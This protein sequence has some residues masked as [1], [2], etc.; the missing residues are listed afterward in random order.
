MHLKPSNGAGRPVGRAIVD[1]L[2][3][4]DDSGRIP[5]VGVTG[6]HGTSLAARLIGW[7]LHLQGTYV[8]LACRDGVFLHERK[9]P[10]RDGMHWDTARQILLN[11][12]VEAAI[13]EN[14]SES[15][16]RDGLV[17]DRCQVGVVTNIDAQDKLPAYYIDDADQMV[18]VT[19]TQVDVV[20]PEGV[21]VLNAADA[22]VAELAELCDGSVIFF[23]AT[24]DATPLAAHR[25]QNGRSVYLRNGDIVLANGA[26]ETVVRKL[27]GLS[28]ATDAANTDSLLAAIGA[29]WALG[30]DAELIRAGIETFEPHG[31]VAPA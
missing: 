25:A 5:V 15:I 27:G 29:A 10:R 28:Y 12:M 4:E 18:K 7:L 22:R 20:L 31:A 1:H 23:A 9:L 24:P 6:S 14:S 3:A 30:L 13:F 17:Y 2:F 11:R 21:A 19:R 8:G 16:L 26:H